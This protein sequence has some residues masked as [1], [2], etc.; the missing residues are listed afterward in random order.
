MGEIV[1][2]GTARVGDFPWQISLLFKGRQHCGGSIISSHWVIT[3]AHCVALKGPKEVRVGGQYW[4]SGSSYKVIG[5]IVHP[6]YDSNI[7]RDDIALVKVAGPIKFS[8][9]NSAGQGAVWPICLPKSLETHS[10]FALATGWG[11]I[12]ENGK[13]SDK[14]KVVSVSILPAASCRR[15]PFFIPATQLCAGYER[16]GRD[17]CQVS[18]QFALL[19]C[20]TFPHHYSHPIFV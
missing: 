3:A 6:Q 16:G 1:G 2:G 4:Y 13:K 20:R 7:M 8:P 17:S 10:G 18:Q 5:E 12:Q 11:A 15:Y 19:F 9:G 14:L